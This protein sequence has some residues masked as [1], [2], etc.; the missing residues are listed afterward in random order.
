MADKY[1]NNYIREKKYKPSFKPNL[2]IGTSE[3]AEKR[4]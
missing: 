1:R 2:N 4:G 3:L